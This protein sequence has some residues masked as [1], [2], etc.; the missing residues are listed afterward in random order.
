MAYSSIT[1]PGDYFN[2]VLY[3]G[4]GSTQSITGVGF[5]PDY[6]W[7]KERASDAVDHKNVDSVRGATK[8][9]ESNTNE[10]EGTATTTVTSFDSDGFSLGSS[11]ATNG[12]SD[13][14]VSW[15]W[16]AGGTAPAITYVVKVVS[17]SGN[18]YRFDDFGTSAVTLELQ[19]G[20][21][22][23]FD[24]SDSSNSGH[25][26]R[27]YTAA[28]KTGGEYTTG[29]TTTGTPGSSGAQTVITVAASAPTL[30]YQCSNHAGMGGQANT[31]SLFGSSNFAG[32][33]Q[34]LVSANT[35]AGFSIVTYSGTGSNA[36]VGHGLGAIPEVMFVKEKS[37]S[38][39]DWVVYHHKNTSA[40]ETDYLILNENNT[41]ADGNTVWNDTAPTSTVFSIGTGSTTN[42]SGS[43]YVAYCFVGKKG[44]CKFG[45]YTGSG[46]ANGPF[47][48]TGFKP[49][50]VILK[51]SSIAE[52]WWIYDNKRNTHNLVTKGL[53]PNAN[54]TEVDYS[55]SSQMNL[56]FLSNGFKL[57]ASDG[58]LNG[59]GQTYIYMAFAE[60]PFVADDS[61]TVVP[62]T[63][64]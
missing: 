25:P 15:N 28:D 62:V 63:A 59:S 56:D 33:Y 20:G 61:G 36:T 29:V 7:L 64:R 54:N 55:G 37:G 41:T 45:G 30:Y 17:D 18:K 13:T 48:H 44:Y 40:P 57:R 51:G 26:L 23:T 19:E 24:Q 14:Y 34:S 27:F 21:T 12:S 60:N 49:A 43:T 58:A 31:N 11:G 1:N 38:V 53:Y 5:Q 4:N 42:R 35:T 8:K 16:L 32:S 47:T 52:N 3:T 2:T 50:M 39:N 22:Y 46:N 9:L 10:L 6:V